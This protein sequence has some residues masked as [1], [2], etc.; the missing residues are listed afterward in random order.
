MEPSCP[1]TRDALT[2]YL[3]VA[4]EHVRRK[5]PD[6][7]DPEALERACAAIDT[8]RRAETYVDENVNVALVLQ[9]LSASLE[10]RTPA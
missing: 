3:R 9:Q 8:I 1:A 5:M 6:L 7:D 2:L 10:Q 4:A